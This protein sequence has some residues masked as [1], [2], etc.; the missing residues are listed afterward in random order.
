MRKI[1]LCAGICIIFLCPVVDAQ[2]CNCQSNLDSLIF[3]IENNYIGFQ[4]KT[5]GQNK[6][7]YRNL[8][9]KIR[10]ESLMCDHFKCYS[11]LSTYLGF[12]KDPHLRMIISR[13]EPGN[14]YLD[15]LR[16]MFAQLP[17][18][19]I[20]LD[21]LTKA[22]SIN[23]DS[24][25]IEGF[26]SLPEY[27]YRIAIIRGDSTDHYEAVI[28][29]ADNLKWFRGQVKMKLKGRNP[30][31]ISFYIADHNMVS[32]KAS[33]VDDVL[34]LGELG[35]WRKERNGVTINTTNT[36]MV[37]YNVLSNKT[38]I[39]KIRSADISYRD[40]LNEI[41]TNNWSD[42]IKKENLI[43]DLRDNSGGHIMTFDTLRSL[44]ATTTIHTDDFYLKS[45][46]DNIELYE[47]AL[48]NPNFNDE[49]KA[50][51]KGL[52][53]TLKAHPDQVVL[54]SK[55]DSI[56]VRARTVP[57]KIAIITNRRTGSAAELFVLYARQSNKVIVVGD[58]TKGALDFTEIG[59]N[60]GLP[61]PMWQYI[62]PMGTGGHKYIPLID[63]IGISPD[64]KIVNNRDWIGWTLNMLQNEN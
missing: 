20:S 5:Q 6:E 56:C 47:E 21:S 63:N 43:I 36:P 35:V 23:S 46:K 22:F 58:N 59:R 29:D 37:S 12:F 24:R 39:I 40:T 25:S 31:D 1:I 17:A 60:R 52:V 44:Y 2:D 42:L 45:S 9:D 64:R 51:F 3:S 34:D 28:I 49:E 11:L 38:A 41:V 26:W 57:E 4:Q 54:I 18:R 19:D 15:T 7:G 48:Y 32:I 16:V 33:A 61:C 27:N 53:D 14:K 13:L 55:D 50:E 30:Y 62:C 10:K 8:V